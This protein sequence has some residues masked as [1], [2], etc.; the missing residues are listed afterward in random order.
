MYGETKYKKKIIP[1]K[2]G[3]M[4]VRDR[5]NNP[6]GG[7]FYKLLNKAGKRIATL[8]KNGKILRD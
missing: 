6:H 1:P 3:W 7:S 2:S 8:D 4:I 5:G